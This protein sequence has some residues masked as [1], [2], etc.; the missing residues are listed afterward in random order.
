MPPIPHR[1]EAM[2]REH[3]SFAVE[4]LVVDSELLESARHAG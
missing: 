2:L 4:D 3:R 1:R